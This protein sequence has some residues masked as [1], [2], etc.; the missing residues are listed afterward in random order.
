MTERTGPFP[1]TSDEADSKSQRKRDAQ[2][3]FKLGQRLVELSGSALDGLPLDEELRAAILEAR[4][5]RAHVARKR[6]L[7]FIARLLRHSE[8]DALIQALEN[9]RG[10]ARAEIARHHRV[11]AWRDGLLQHGDAWL[12]VLIGQCPEADH[13]ALRTLVRNAR[14]EASLGRPPASSRKLFQMLR[15]L[16]S[17]QALPP[18]PGSG[19]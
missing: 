16:D 14:K 4:H 7:G 1:E 9:L 2:A 5:M 11:E 18:L 13:Q 19:D 6:Q 15:S 12:A 8:V 17:G 10:E 3:L